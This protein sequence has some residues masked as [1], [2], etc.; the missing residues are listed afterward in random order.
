MAKRSSLARIG[1]ATMLALVLLVVM[2]QAAFAGISWCDDGDLAPMAM[3]AESALVGTP[4]ET[5]IKGMEASV[6]LIAISSSK[7]DLGG[8]N[9]GNK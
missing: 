6:P 1:L 9:P 4:N 3:K 7:T 5:K 8:I 2:A